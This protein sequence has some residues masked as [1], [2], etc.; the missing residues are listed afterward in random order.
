MSECENLANCGFFKKY[1]DTKNLACMG[2]IRLYCQGSHMN[3]CKRK[4]YK[5]AHGTPPDDDMMPN[6]FPMAD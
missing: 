4:E 2:F 6:G 3:E 5:K 1:K